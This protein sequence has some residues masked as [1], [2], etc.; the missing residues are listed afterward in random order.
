ML[1]REATAAIPLLWC[2]VGTRGASNRLHHV[3][4][5]PLLGI[6]TGGARPPGAG[7]R[8][9]VLADDVGLG[10]TVAIIALIMVDLLAADDS[11]SAAGATAGV[12]AA[13]EDGVGPV[14][15]CGCSRTTLIACPAVLVDQWRDELAANA[16]DL[17]VAV[18]RTGGEARRRQDSWLAAHD[19]VVV[20]HSVLVRFPAPKA[21][22]RRDGGGMGAT[23]GGAK[24]PLSGLVWRRIVVDEGHAIKT[25][26]KLER[27]LAAL[28]AWA[29][30]VVTGTPFA[31]GSLAAFAGPLRFL[32]LHGVAD[33][34]KGQAARRR[35]AGLRTLVRSL[36]M[37]HTKDHLDDV[38]LPPVT[39]VVVPVSQPS[40]EAAAYALLARVTAAALRK[41]RAIT[42]DLALDLLS[43]L[44]RAT[45]VGVGVRLGGGGGGISGGGSAGGTPFA[46]NASASD[47]AAAQ[48]PICLDRPMENPVVTPC[49]HSFCFECIMGVLLH[50]GFVSSCP[51]CRA[52]ISE[53]GLTPLLGADAAGGGS[54]DADGRS[55]GGG[56]G[57][58]SD[59]IARQR[60]GG[61]DDR[62]WLNLL[63]Y[64]PAFE[65]EIVVGG[66]RRRG[67]AVTTAKVEALAEDV[68]SEM[69]D[70]ARHSKAVIFSLWSDALVEI[71]DAVRDEQKKN[72]DDVWFI[73]SCADDLRRWL[74]QQGWMGG[75]WGLKVV[76]ER[77][78]KICLWFRLQPRP[79]FSVYVF[80]PLIFF[81]AF[82][83]FHVAVRYRV[84]RSIC[85]CARSIRKC[86]GGRAPRHSPV[87]ADTAVAVRAVVFCPL[88]CDTR[89]RDLF[90]CYGLLHRSKPAFPPLSF[91]SQP[92]PFPFTVRAVDVLVLSVR[93]AS[94]GLD[95]SAASLLY[96]VD[97]VWSAAIVEQMVGRV[98]RIGQ[99]AGEVVVK[100]LVV[101]G[102]IDAS[103]AAVVAGP[104]NTERSPEA[105]AVSVA[106]DL[107]ASDA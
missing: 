9:G 8:G 71:A 95:L 73:S 101:A 10:K 92:S 91:L 16:P 19:V 37:R 26:G 97:V 74:G 88:A 89:E 106:S 20:S 105:V 32:G 43:N 45:T 103:L 83:T 69:V 107:A 33:V 100:T 56:S 60:G 51:I 35:G 28:P 2:Q 5:S 93:M 3:W 34:I 11:T 44:R 17:R 96:A 48:C 94:T 87:F 18:V 13:A 63:F 27:V 40:R 54:G 77:C 65:Y 81:P 57:D 90:W 68:W 59:K 104:S 47:A 24:V 52:R 14:D 22:A 102:T 46:Y 99:E 66:R 85:R 64:D 15:A 79:L 76:Q 29:R 78:R 7:A 61:G 98:W 70:Q 84:G 31:A 23:P 36:V 1:E 42:P 39:A 67:E 41:A 75:G 50:S 58:G 21:A 12:D 49:R 86:R 25:G 53:A 72:R 82:V 38:E 30:W 62:P 55:D 80:L 4:V 6:V